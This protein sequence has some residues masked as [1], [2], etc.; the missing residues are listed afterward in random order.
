V[1]R[2]LALVCVLFWCSTANAAAQ[3]AALPE[4]DT[5]EEFDAYLRVLAATTPKTV[6]EA[7]AD[8]EKQWPGSAL[9]GHV[10]QLE[11]E[12]FR[13][14]GDAPRAIQAGEK[15]LQSLPDNLAVL[16]DL[17]LLLANGARDPAR[18]NRAE[19]CARKLLE[20][21]KG[22]RL[23]K[24]IPPRQWLEDQ[25]RLCSQAHAALGLVANQ[26]GQISVAIREF[27]TAV[28]LAPAPDATQIY[29][30]GVL[31]HAAGRDDEARK[32]FERAAVMNQPL[33]REL[34]EKEL[35]ALKH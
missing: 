5:P 31:Y 2:S 15:A 22:F 1:F 17:S 18:L 16:A 10:Y 21:V 19:Q 29:R 8:F 13:A 24:W 14:L 9:R 3:F 34:A 32:T 11:L 23:P 20:L 26:R 6:I 35:A 27:E 25:A 28:S 4:A 30:L 7:A 12:A 33:I